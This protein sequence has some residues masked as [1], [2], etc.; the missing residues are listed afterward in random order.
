[1][2]LRANIWQYLLGKPRQ[3]SRLI[4]TAEADHDRLRAGGNKRL[5]PCNTLFRRAG[6]ETVLSRLH[7]VRY[8][9]IVFNE[10]A[11]LAFCLDDI[12]D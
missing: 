5:E 9:I 6:A 2:T 8:T 12:G 7:L 1:M 4:G 11:Q 10:G 3:L